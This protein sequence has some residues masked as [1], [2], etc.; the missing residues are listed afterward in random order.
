MRI[1]KQLSSTTPTALAL[2]VL[3]ALFTSLEYGNGRSI[4]CVSA[5]DVSF[6]S[7]VLRGNLNRSRAVFN[8]THRG[9]VVFMG[10]SI[11]EMDGYRPMVCETLKKRFPETEF[12]FVNAGIASTCSHTGAFRVPTDILAHKPDLLLIEF[13][14]NDDQDAGHSYENALRGMEGIVRAAR[15][16]NPK[17]DIVITHFVN[18]TMLEAI[19]Q[20]K[21][22]TSIRAH[23]SVAEHYEISTCNV[24]V[25]L[26]KR[27]ASGETSWKIYGG[28][29]PKPAGNRIAADLVEQVFE[30]NQFSGDAQ[31]TDALA[32]QSRLP[33][34]APIDPT[35]FSGGHYLDATRL[36]LGDGWSTFQPDWKKIPGSF[37]A[38]FDGRPLTIAETPGAEMQ[39]QFQGTSIGLYVLAGPDAGMLQ[40]AIDDG[41]WHD[42]DLY[43]H[44]S[45]GLHYP[46]TV[47]LE[48]GLQPGKHTLRLRVSTAQNPNSRG[49]AV[50]VLEFVASR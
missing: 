25:E 36:Q 13:A 50:R 49:H 18:P 8:Q 17:L 5:A 35:S 7:V 24:A 46:R 31:S 23:E 14:V 33:L 32:T 48:S 34:P 39:L 43:H 40:Y 27:I 42:R 28:V 44:Y 26:A 37:R 4:R 15:K 3:W 41:A 21:V 1:L 12:R 22:P 16:S 9:T 47:V 38:R 29:H 19:Q 2:C 20:G 6:P 10:G 30:A 11:T 45:K